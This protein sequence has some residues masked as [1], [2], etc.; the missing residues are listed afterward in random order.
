MKNLKLL[1][2]VAISAILFS[3][4]AKDPMALFGVDSDVVYVGDEVTF[5]NASVD[6][7]T[8]YWDFGDGSHS[9]EFSPKH[10]YEAAGTYNVYLHA[11]TKKNASVASL[12]ITVKKRSELVVNG[13]HYPIDGVQVLYENST[14]GGKNYYLYF[15]NKSEVVYNS[16]DQYFTGRGSMLE[17][18]L[19][20]NALESGTYLYNPNV[21]PIL[22]TCD[23]IEAYT[24]YDFNN[25]N[26]SVFA[27]D[28]G[29]MVVTKNGNN[30]TFEIEYTNN[31]S[32]KVTCYMECAITV[33][34]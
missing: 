4:C 7:D 24:N 18:D 27:A 6:A 14:N 17:V 33:N 28:S 13:N 5:K 26:G 15:Y 10:T 29:S 34:F 23:W 32:D 19:C 11:N 2:I 12:V 30:Y 22:G 16:T 20:A 3:G 9:T 8:Y 21:T 1:M 25:D 31:N